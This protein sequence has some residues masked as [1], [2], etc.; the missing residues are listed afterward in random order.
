MET[1]ESICVAIGVMVGIILL[2][3]LYFYF[4]DRDKT[5]QRRNQRDLNQYGTTR[6][7]MLLQ[8]ELERLREENRNLRITQEGYDGG[9]NLQGLQGVLKDTP[10]EQIGAYQWPEYEQGGGINPEEQ[11]YDFKEPVDMETWSDDLAPF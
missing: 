2:V 3:F 11:D 10:D 6:Q 5:S 1:I 7:G 4:R 8:D 9:D